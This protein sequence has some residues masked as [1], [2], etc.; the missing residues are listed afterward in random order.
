MGRGIEVRIPIET[1]I[2][3]AVLVG[4]EVPLE[5]PRLQYFV[6]EYVKDRRVYIH[7][8]TGRMV[9][10]EVFDDHREWACAFLRG[11]I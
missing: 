1:P 5:P 4:G 8:T 2:Q 9:V 3:N 10:R 6:L 11:L 7:P